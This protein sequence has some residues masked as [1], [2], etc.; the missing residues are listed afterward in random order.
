MKTFL[1]A[2][3]MVSMAGC[4]VP[5]ETNDVQELR[6]P[7]ANEAMVEIADEEVY[8]DVQAVNDVA[9]LYQEASDEV[10]RMLI[11]KGG[12]SFQVKSVVETR[13][14]IAALVKEFEGYVAN[15]SSGSTVIVQKIR[16]PSASLEDFMLKAESFADKVISKHVS[17]EDVTEEFI[18]LES[19]VASKRKTEARYQEIL[20]AAMKVEEIMSIE[21]QLDIIRANI[22]SMEGR[23]EY[24][25]K[26]TSMAE[27]EISYQEVEP[28][29]ANGFNADLAE[30]FGYG[31]RRVIQFVLD[32]VAIW[33]T[34]IVISTAFVFV[35]LY[36]RRRRRAVQPV[37]T[38]QS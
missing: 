14:K 13:K 27:L 2:L 31:W 15:E 9:V 33:P 5:A 38:I 20:K 6:V 10:R 4:D 24:L 28:F 36:W 37:A 19:R 16:V 8:E 30:S 7:P 35:F 18:D 12:I 29:V 21:E 25:K 17:A 32:F 22:E 3:T 34:V 11:R 26:R 23:I 1:I